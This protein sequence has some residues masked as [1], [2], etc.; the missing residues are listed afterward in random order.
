MGL[1]DGILLGLDHPEGKI[2]Y[3]IEI[4]RNSLI[5]KHTQAIHLAQVGKLAM[6][7]KGHGPINPNDE[8]I[9]RLL[10]ELSKT[11]FTHP[12]RATLNYVTKF[13]GGG[14]PEQQAKELTKMANWIMS[15]QRSDSPDQYDEWNASRIYNKRLVFALR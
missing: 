11:P 15:T 4:L 14:P 7:Q 5:R 8:V 10:W 2:N 12:V 3:F 13:T 6:G 1:V 9:R